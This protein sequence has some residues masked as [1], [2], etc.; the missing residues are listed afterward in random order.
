VRGSQREP[1]HNCGDRVLRCVGVKDE[2]EVL[3]G[4]G[5]PAA[6]LLTSRL[7]SCLGTETLETVKC[8]TVDEA[9]EEISVL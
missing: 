1:H 9:W 6:A 2:M 8:G 3:G 7:G 5:G 4:D